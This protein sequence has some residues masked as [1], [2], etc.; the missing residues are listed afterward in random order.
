[1]AK[2]SDGAASRFPSPARR[3]ARLRACR[4]QGL[5]A[6]TVAA[7]AATGSALAFD[8]IRVSSSYQGLVQST[9]HGGHWL[10]FDMT[11]PDIVQSSLSNFTEAPLSADQA[12]CVVSDYSQTGLPEYFALGFGVA[13]GFTNG[14][15]VIAHN[16]PNTQSQLSNLKGI[17]HIDSDPIGYAL[18][19]VI[20]NDCGYT[21]PEG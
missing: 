16:N 10:L 11:N 2:T 17:D 12:S 14:P 4:T 9:S 6:V 15:G 19:V 1:M 5:L 21:I 8:C 20:A 3:V 13:G 18:A 7:L